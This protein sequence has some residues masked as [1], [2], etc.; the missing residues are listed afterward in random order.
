MS[1]FVGFDFAAICWIFELVS[2]TS[3]TLIRLII[4]IFRWWNALTLH[5]AVIMKNFIVCDSLELSL[6]SM[7]YSN[8]VIAIRRTK[9]SSHLDPK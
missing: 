7:L 8:V 1:F 9:K 6:F 5:Y 4:Y 3:E 2:L